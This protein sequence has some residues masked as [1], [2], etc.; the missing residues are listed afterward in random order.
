MQ[1]ACIYCDVEE[2]GAAVETIKKHTARKEHKCT[3]CGDIIKPG[4]QYEK[5]TGLWNNKWSTYKTCMDCISIRDE[6]FCEGWYYGQIWDYLC[7]HIREAEG[8]I[9]SDCI[10]SLTPGAQEVVFDIIE[11]VWRDMEACDG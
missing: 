10:T 5:V 2:A 4:E 3:E 11:D 6:F 9:S 8:Q 7:D 1:C